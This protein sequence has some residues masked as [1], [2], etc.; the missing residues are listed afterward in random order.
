M[1]SSFYIVLSGSASVYVSSKQKTFQWERSTAV[2]RPLT[3]RD[4]ESQVPVDDIDAQNKQNEDSRGDGIEP[5]NG[6]SSGGI[7]SRTESGKRKAKE[8]AGF[9]DAKDASR[10]RVSGRRS[11]LGKFSAKIGQK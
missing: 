4:E 2:A 1:S 9:L 10:E 3:D 7:V 5:D 6:S 11:S 8:K